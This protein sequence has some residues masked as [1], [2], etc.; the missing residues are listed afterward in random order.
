MPTPTDI[1]KE[2]QKRID[3]YISKT[4][5]DIKVEA[6][7]EFDANFNRQAFFNQ[8]WAR[9]KYNDD[10]SR[11]LLVQSGTLRRSITAK[12]TDRDSVLFQTTVPY[13]RI[14]NEGGTIT[15][16]SRM[17]KYFWWKYITIVGS[18]RPKA[19][20]ATTYSERFQRK[21]NGELR[22]NRRNRELTE[23]AKFYKYMAMKKTGDKITIPKRQFIGNHPDLEKLLKEIAEKNAIEI[24]S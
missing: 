12:I 2:L 13:A 17:K 19:G 9:R 6:A 24:F 20:T 11:G 16:T 5:K 8:K 15:V 3:R 23:E 1:N 21:K 4:L 14:H 7:D 18:K 22:N 10:E